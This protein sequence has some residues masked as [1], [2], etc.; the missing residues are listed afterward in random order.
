MKKQIALLASAVLAVSMVTSCGKNNSSS[1]TG[2]K[3]ENSET[4]N[5]WQKSLLEAQGLPTD[6]EQLSPTQKRSIQHIYEMIT[7]LNDKYDEEFVYAGYIEGGLM[8]EERLFAYPK[9]Y[10]ADSGRNTVEV[11]VGDN[12][13][14]TDNYSSIEVRDYCENLYNDFI[15]DYFNSDEAVLLIN[16]FSSDIDS[17]SEIEGDDFENKVGGTNIICISDKICDEELIKD[18]MAKFVKWS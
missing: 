1:Q 7:Y 15:R 12:G 8:E 9:Q 3:W 13:D 10:G 4:L 14:F 2:H 11:T 16:F 5:E 18:F 17:L 6:I